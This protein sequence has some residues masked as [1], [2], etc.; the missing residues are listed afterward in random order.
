MDLLRTTYE[1]PASYNPDTQG[2]AAVLELGGCLGV[3]SCTINKRLGDPTKHVVLEANP[4]LIPYLRGNREINRA[5]FIV[6][7][8]VVFGSGSWNDHRGYRA[9]SWVLLHGVGDGY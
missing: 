3:L 4:A 2:G 5:A 1:P 8:S 7:N 9:R 6:T